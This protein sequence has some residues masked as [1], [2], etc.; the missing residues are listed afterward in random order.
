[1]EVGGR[2]VR[3]YFIPGRFCIANQ[4]L[5]RDLPTALLSP[6]AS[7]QASKQSVGKLARLGDKTKHDKFLLVFHK[8]LSLCI[9]PCKVINTLA[10]NYSISKVGLE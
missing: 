2:L 7:C 8:C 1:M 3:S 4:L 5:M 6:H 9:H 10:K